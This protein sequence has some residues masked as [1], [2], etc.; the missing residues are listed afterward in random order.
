MPDII[1]F[2]FYAF[3]I[4]FC[5]VTLSI[6]FKFY[7][8]VVILDLPDFFRRSFASHWSRSSQLDSRLHPEEGLTYRREEKQ[9]WA[10]IQS[11]HWL[12]IFRKSEP[13]FVCLF[14]FF[15]ETVKKKDNKTTEQRRELRCFHPFIY[16]YSHFA[17]SFLYF[18]FFVWW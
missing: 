14:F 13:L 1:L 18:C 16:F 3:I 2:H 6:F 5:N 11:L 15:Y 9:H 17:I 4:T 10:G 12:N 8:K 7:S